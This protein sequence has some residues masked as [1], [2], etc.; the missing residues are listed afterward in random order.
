MLFRIGPLTL[1]AT[2]SGNFAFG[3][4]Q[5]L[6]RDFRLGLGTDRTLHYDKD[7]AHQK[8]VSGSIKRIISGTKSIEATVLQELLH[9]SK[10]LET[11]A[12]VQQ[13]ATRNERQEAVRFPTSKTQVATTSL[14]L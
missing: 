10:S 2:I 14:L 12:R 4:E 8:M 11:V 5:Q 7:F 6:P 1:L 9:N 13:T 3:T